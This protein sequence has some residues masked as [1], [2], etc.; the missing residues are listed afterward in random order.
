MV[1][2]TV[3]DRD[4]RVIDKREINRDLFEE[5]LRRERGDYATRWFIRLLGAI[6]TYTSRSAARTITVVDE[7]GTARTVYTQYPAYSSSYNTFNSTLSGDVGAII[8]VGTGTAPPTR[9]DYKLASELARAWASVSVAEDAGI[10]T[11]TAGFTWATNQTISEIG[12]I[13]QACIQMSPYVIT[14][15]LD[16]TVLSSPVSVPAGA[17]LT[18]A[19]RFRL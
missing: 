5:Y 18:V 13:L 9:D 16:R 10:V 12:L 8:A 2:V 3:I 19:Y 1:E 6:F 4:G 17:T 15:L 14:F 11:L 7:T